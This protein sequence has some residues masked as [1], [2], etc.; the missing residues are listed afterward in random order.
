MSF[1]IR[2]KIMRLDSALGEV[3]NELHELKKAIDEDGE[4]QAMAF[5]DGKI[6]VNGVEYPISNFTVTWKHSQVED[7][8]D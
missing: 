4:R 2:N 5:K 8:T 1:K 3:M 6:I 7:E